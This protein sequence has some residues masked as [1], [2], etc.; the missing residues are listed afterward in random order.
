E[1]DGMHMHRITG[2]TPW[3]DAKLKASLARVR[4][5]NRVLDVCTGLGYTAIAALKSGACNIL[6][7]EVDRNVLLLAEY[8]PWSKGLRNKSIKII[9]GDAYDILPKL[10][11][12]SFDK[13][14]H[15]PPRP[16]FAPMLYS[17]DFYTELYRV[18]K[19]RGILFHYTGSP[20]KRR[21]VDIARGVMRRL[22]R[23]GFKVKRC[24]PAEGVLAFK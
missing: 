21:G 22:Q 15:D 7:I 2:I 14:I 23:A 3:E 1:I 19:P 12:S 18:L 17:Y 13:I 4:Y 16:A 10:E 6:S 5:C 11:T 9:L 20:G 8:N 24:P